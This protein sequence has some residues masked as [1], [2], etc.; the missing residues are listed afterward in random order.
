M[1]LLHDMRFSVRGFSAKRVAY[2][3]ASISAASLV[4][5]F[6]CDHQ[7]GSNLVAFA[8]LTLLPLLILSLFTPRSDRRRF[9][10]QL[11]GLVSFILHVV[12]FNL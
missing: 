9:L 10:P 5:H 1:N 2:L 12:L 4:L 8:L 7:T 6:H 11:L 3:L